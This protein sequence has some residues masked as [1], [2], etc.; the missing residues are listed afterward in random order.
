MRLTPLAESSPPA[1]GQLDALVDDVWQRIA[2]GLD[3]R[4]PPWS[5]PTLATVAADGPRARILALRAANAAA[6]TFTFHADARSQKTREIAADPRVCVVFWDPADGIEAR[7]TGRAELLHRGN[8]VADG[9][10]EN[11]SPL[12]RLASRSAEAPGAKLSNPTRFDDL[13]LDAEHG[14]RENFVVIEVHVDN[15][16]WLWVGAD[17]MRRAAFAWTGTAWTGSWTIP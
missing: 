14:G 8:A 6:R 5:L 11:V 17:D 13:P 1:S 16:D 3:G 4:W 12:R 2:R 7:F 15:L 9:A 10:W